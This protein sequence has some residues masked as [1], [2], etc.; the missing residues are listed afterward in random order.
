MLPKV[1]L[2]L[3][4]AMP[5][6]TPLIVALG[7]TVLSGAS[8]FSNWIPWI[9]AF[10]SFSSC[11]AFNLLDVKMAFSKPLPLISCMIILQVV[12]PALAY[13]V[14]I[15]FLHGDIYTITGVV[16]TFIIPT[17][18]VTLMWVSIYG[19]NVGLSVVIVLTNTLLSPIIV[20]F[21]LYLFVGTKVSIDILGLF[22]G[23]L[24]MVAIPSVLGMTVNRMTDGKSKR[25]GKTLAPFTKIC[26]M[27]V[28]LIN[29]AVVSPYFE[30]IDANLIYTFLIVLSLACMGYLIGFFT[31]IGFNWNKD[32]VISL[33]Y[34]SGMRNTGVGAA[35][36]VTYFPSATVLP[37]VLAIVFQQFLASV[38][39]QI[40]VKYFEKNVNLWNNII[41]KLG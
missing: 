22:N 27:I 2:V 1:N 10:I 23:L 6:L 26:V 4:K 20:P 14:G 30:R 13:V 3:E 15:L 11:L 41:R 31:A 18:V 8:G 17:G 28:I 33:M 25:L 34:N 38:A 16:L 19:G 12:M 24:W 5:L 9:F 35:L 37:V 7:I 29:S 21:V 40:S 39:G 36:A 32:Y